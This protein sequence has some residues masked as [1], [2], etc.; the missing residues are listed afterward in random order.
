MCTKIQS[1]E[2]TIIGFE[3]ISH[4][5]E[6]YSAKSCSKFEKLTQA[7]LRGCWWREALSKA[8]DQKLHATQTDIQPIVTLNLNDPRRAILSFKDPE[9]IE[10]FSVLES[11]LKVNE[12]RKRVLRACAV[13]C[14]AVT[15]FRCLLGSHIA[16]SLV[17]FRR[18]HFGVHKTTT[19]QLFF[20]EFKGYSRARPTTLERRHRV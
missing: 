13:I 4:L 11:K 5:R 9:A 8:Y 7:N 20:A 3:G 15:E 2:N 19:S 1:P 14:C 16:T 12:V 10:E 18:A 6:E 17:P